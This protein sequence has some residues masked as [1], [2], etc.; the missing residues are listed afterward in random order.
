MVDESGAAD[1]DPGE[2]A[3]R[4]THRTTEATDIERVMAAMVD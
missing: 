3:T 1:V 2:H 4:L